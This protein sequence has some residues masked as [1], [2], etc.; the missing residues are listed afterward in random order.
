M[1]WSEQFLFLFQIQTDAFR[2]RRGRPP[3]Y[4]KHDIPVV[5]KLDMSVLAQM[6]NFPSQSLLEGFIEYA[7]GTW[8]LVLVHLFSSRLFNLMCQQTSDAS[9]LI[10]TF[11]RA[12]GTVTLTQDVIPFFQR[13]AVSGREVLLLLEQ[14]LPLR[15][16]ALPPR[17]RPRRRAQ[18]AR[19]GIPQP[20]HHSR[21]IRVL[22]PQ[23]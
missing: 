7:E 9:E 2:R 5:P 1:N 4:P 22:W 13:W 16:A 3:K 17:V 11:P 15:E 14:T 12:W 18:P 23:C 21:G 8:V 19:Q 6:P 10:L 20:R